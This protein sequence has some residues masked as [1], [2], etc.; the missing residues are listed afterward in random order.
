M[1]KQILKPTQLKKYFLDKNYTC[2]KPYQ[3]VDN[4]STVFVTAG[5]QP[6]LLKFCD[7]QLENTKKIY[8]SQPVIRTQFANNI[9]EGTSI[10]FINLTTAGFNISIE[11]HNELVNDC[12]ELFYMLGLEPQKMKTREKVYERQWGNLSVS[13]IKTF[14]YYNEI[15]LGDTTFFTSVK[16]DGKDIGIK[17]MSDVGFGIER[18]KWCITNNSYFNIYSDSQKIL[19]EIK[20]YLSAIALLAINDIKPSNKNAGYRYRLF[21]KKLVDIM[22]GTELSLEI[23]K[24]LNECIDY[25]ENWQEIDKKNIIDNIEKEYIRNCNRYLLNKLTN[26]GYNNISGIN[27]NTTREDF[28]KRLL[29]SGIERTKIKK[30]TK[31]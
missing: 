2:L 25:W 14:Y 31:K 23:K 19:P 20:A 3:I 16:K 29:A 5:I 4:N 1:D 17:T 22:E 12:L 18:I 9:C 27:I 26:E 11:E 13:G 15:E 8:I 7:N 30:L 24:Y 21:T 10:A 28:E 6:I